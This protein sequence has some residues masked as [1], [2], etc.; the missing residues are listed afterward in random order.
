MPRYA[1][2]EARVTIGEYRGRLTVRWTAADAWT[3]E[4]VK[5][6]FRATFGRHSQATWNATLKAW[7][8]PHW[9]Y[10]A[11]A[12]WTAQTF[13]REAVSWLDEDE[14]RGADDGTSYEYRRGSGRGTS[15]SGSRTPDPVTNAYAALHLLPSAPDDLVTAAHRIAIRLAHPDAGGSHE[16]AVVVNAAIATIRE[17][18]HARAP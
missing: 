10:D 12:Y 17:A 4:G 13:Q 11:L 6:S 14:E 3:F 1:A 7:T 9:Q 5:A 15:H 2:D 16:A 18:Q 8:L